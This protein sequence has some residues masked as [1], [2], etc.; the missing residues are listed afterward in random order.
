M[1]EGMQRAFFSAT[2]YSDHSVLL[3]LQNAAR[4][5]YLVRKTEHGPMIREDVVEI[6]HAVETIDEATSPAQLMRRLSEKLGC[7]GFVSCLMTDLPHPKVKRWQEHILINEWPRDWYNRYLEAGHYHHDPCVA[8]SRSGTGPFIW[9]DIVERGV[10]REAAV[11]MGEARELGLR[12]GICIPI[13]AGGDNPAVVT[14]AGRYVDLSPSARCMVHA[15]ARHAYDAAARLVAHDRQD[16]SQPLSRR[17]REILLWVAE[18]KTAW[19]ISRILTISENTVNTHMR[20]MRGKL[21]T[22]NTVHTVTEA[23]RRGEIQL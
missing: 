12:D 11:V 1:R 10:D 18:G 14:V 20:N 9:S 22:S 3:S 4:G 19:E 23:L 6:F 17:E 16:C 13:V 5:S 2:Y 8:L 7:L 21:N 15:L